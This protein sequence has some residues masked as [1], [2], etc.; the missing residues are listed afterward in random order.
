MHTC[1]ECDKKLATGGGLEIHMELAHKPAAPRQAAPAG[2]PVT[3]P[4]PAPVDVTPIERPRRPSKLSAV[5]F[6]AMAIVALLV[7]GVATALARRTESTTTPGAASATTPLALV[8]AS[9]STT[10]ATKTAQ[11]SVALQGGSGLFKSFSETGGFDFENRRFRVEIDMA[12]FGQ[13]GLGKVEGIA[14]F[15]NGLIEYVHLPAE[16][17]NDMGGK[18]WIKIDLQALLQRT[19]VN[20]NLGALLQ[21]QSGDPTQGLGMVRG[22]ENVVAVGT[23][24]VRGA[25][26]THYHLDVNLQKAVD[27]QPTPEARAAMQQLVNLYT[28]P[29]RPVDV[30]LDSDG[31]VRRLQQTLDFSVV[32]FPPAIAGQVQRLGSPT[33]TVEYYGFGQ[34]VDTQLP[35]PDQVADLSALINQGR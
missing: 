29:T 33:L 11:I 2:V 28:V 12:Q 13:P 20:A 26:A 6:I 35:S 7:A 19:G 25:E 23:E 5:P 22:A 32:R 16:A 1:P 17:A 24:Q 18:R 4:A 10:A 15:S 9:A 3:A 21:G 27:Q 31:R 34:S 14:D 30:W 8:Q